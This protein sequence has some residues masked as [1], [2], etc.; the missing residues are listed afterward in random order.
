MDLISDPQLFIRIVEAG[1]LKR[2][3]E[4][5][6]T[7]PSTVTRRLSAIEHRLGVTLLERSRQGSS[8]TEAGQRYYDE[9]RKIVP[10]VE[11]LEAEVAGLKD[12]P[13][14][15]V[16]ISSPLDFGASYVTKW[17]TELQ[18]EHS[19]LSVDLLLSDAYVDLAG[20]GI[21]I[22]MRIG[23]LSDSA[24]IA[25]RLGAMPLMIV[26]SPGYLSDNGIPS[27]P[28]D[29]STHSFVLYSWMQFGRTLSLQDA[30]GRI[31]KVPLGSRLA[32][33][34]VGAIRNAVLS[35]AGLHIGPE[36]IFADDLETGVINEVMSDYSIA[37]APVHAIYRPG[38]YLPA[39]MR[40]VLD[41][42]RDNCRTVRGVTS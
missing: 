27:T 28:K 24:L 7:D 26:G 20:E 17:I 8:P 36:W 30:E 40:V 3:A 39:K 1:S 9:M 18:R 42:L 22:A 2:V 19:D 4:E 32:I 31:E 16:R 5:L 15:L 33:N 21:D 38:P 25:R 34:N 23:N 29:L 11:A 37:A 14:G 10:A 41:M 35:G 13:R 12:T 6:E